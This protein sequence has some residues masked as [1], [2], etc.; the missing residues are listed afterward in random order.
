MIGINEIKYFPLQ[1]QNI[2]IWICLTLSRNASFL[3]FVNMFFF[4]YT[5]K[6]IPKSIY[7]FFD[8]AL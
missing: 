2:K 5:V 3:G 4:P 7:V 8:I 1:T 6:S